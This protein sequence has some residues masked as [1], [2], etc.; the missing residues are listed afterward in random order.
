M[1]SSYTYISYVL[2]EIY[3]YSAVCSLLVDMVEKISQILGLHKL[4][5][6]EVAVNI[7]STI[8]RC[9]VQCS[10]RGFLQPAE[11]HRAARGKE[12]R[13]HTKLTDRFGCIKT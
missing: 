10:G 5:E 2:R 4:L 8:C 11:T 9:T 3:N 6:V 13:G 1:P 12:G 7:A